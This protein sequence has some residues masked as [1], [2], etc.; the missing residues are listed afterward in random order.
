MN[1]LMNGQKLQF[2]TLIPG[3]NFTAQNISLAAWAW[4]GLALL[5][6][7]FILK[8]KAPYGRYVSSKW[9]ITIPNKLGWFLMEIISPAMLLGSFFWSAQPKS[10]F[11][12]FLVL[13]WCLHY[14]NRSII[15]PLRTKTN[16]K[17][18]PLTL[19]LFAIIFNGINALLNGCYLGNFTTTPNWNTN[20]IIRIAGGF[21]IFISGAYINIRS[22]NIL[23]NLRQPGESS[24][25]IPQGFL[26]K[27]IS[28]PN[29]LGEMI[30]WIGFAI[31]AWNIPALSFAVWTIANL[32]PRTFHLHQWYVANFDNYPR[33]RKALLPFLW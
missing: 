8:N 19:V 17:V 23:L 32:A 11:A 33:N 2:N 22:D 27:Y 6:L 24:Y 18:I 28:C 26:F 16:G 13:L 29:L 9:G 14:F 25:K 5:L 31:M 20:E 10:G 4:I 30:E 3:M 12:I 7:P 1:S 21:L 15:F